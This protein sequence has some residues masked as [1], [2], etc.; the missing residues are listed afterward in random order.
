[1]NQYH[2]FGYE[3]LI[4]KLVFQFCIFFFQFCK[5]FGLFSQYKQKYLPDIFSG[6][7]DQYL[8]LLFSF[9]LSDKNLFPDQ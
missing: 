8:T 5:T 1:M 6:I 7:F 2:T 9:L 4:V 3:K